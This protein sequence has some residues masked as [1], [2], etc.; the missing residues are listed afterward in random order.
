[1]MIKYFI[2]LANLSHKSTYTRL[3]SPL[4]VFVSKNEKKKKKKHTPQLGMKPH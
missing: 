3:F 4:C 1:M 2:T